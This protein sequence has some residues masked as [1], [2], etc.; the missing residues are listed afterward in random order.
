MKFQSKL[1]Q[2]SLLVAE[3]LLSTANGYIG[4]RGNFEEG[5]RETDDTIR[6]TY[7]NAFHEVVDVAYGENAYGFPQTA[8]KMLNLIDAQTILVAVDGD[9]FSLALGEVLEM[10]RDLDLDQGVAM[11]EVLWLSPKGHKI[12][13]LIKRMTSFVNRELFMID[14]AIE[15]INFSGQI[16]IL[17]TLNGDVSNYTSAN[18]PRVSSGHAKL[19]KVNG[20]RIEDQIISI[21]AG[22]QRAQLKMAATVFHDIPMVYEK[23][24]QS[25]LGRAVKY[26]EKG[27][28]FN[29]TKYVVY[30]DSLRHKD[31]IQDGKSILQ[32][33]L[34]KGKMKLYAEQLNY[35]SEFWKYAR[36]DIEG[37]ES[38]QE[39]VLYSVYQLLASAG[40]DPH[41][42]LCAKG[43]SGEGYEGHYFW[44]TEI[45]ALPFFTL[46]DPS[47]A[48]N[49]LKFR[50]TTLE[51]AKLEARQLGYLRGAKF[52]WRTISGSECSGYFPAGTAQY[53][54]NADVAYSNI[55]YFLVHHDIDLLLESGYEVLVET[56]RLWTE[57][58]HF[59]ENGEFRIDAVTG[60]DEYTAVVNNNYFTNAMAKYHLEWT[61]KLAKILE[62]ADPSRWSIL[63]KRIDF[64][65]N[66]LLIMKRA[67]EN[68][69]LPFSE[70]LNICLQDDSFINKK[71]W[72]FEHTP[73]ENYPLL[74]HYHPLTIYRHKVMKQADTV[75]A[76]LLLDNDSDEVI[77]NTYEYYEKFTTHDSSLSYCVYGI[78][79]SRINDPEKAVKFFNKNIR[80]DLDNLH[81]NT[82]DGLHL[83]NAGGV[84]MSIVYG[85]GGLRIKENGL[86]LRPNKP[87]E[88]NS[89]TFRI[90]YRNRLVKVTI[91]DD[92]R[93]QCDEPIEIYV[94]E[95]KYKVDQQ[96]H[97]LY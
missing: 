62:D 23:Q 6:G 56:A 69:F 41:S 40:K 16:E 7:I 95:K 65:E 17:S 30:T 88:W 57:T 97:L 73:K 27:E 12:K 3:S 75:L 31:F 37:D 47:I 15:S 18:D 1:D 39:A 33:V 52:P 35:L 51:N 81:H 28:L 86:H 11:R 14:Y 89:L 29:F 91:A 78:M 93:I 8:Q 32:E 25:I 24:N 21:D 26:I 2:A 38:A 64:S 59:I 9:L 85:F 19:L 54:I 53:H 22:V 83:A 82:K 74:L 20:L 58:G 10:R 50:L 61:V 46:T 70:E 71:D 44:D 67:G 90:N 36:V 84:Y 68:M 94:N 79:A 43:L 4:V 72:D 76:H 45:Y 13:F 92:L 66:E 63:K 49:L 55:Q 96:L 77:Q 60:P 5:Y 42:N 87:K 48:Q 80:L 34:G